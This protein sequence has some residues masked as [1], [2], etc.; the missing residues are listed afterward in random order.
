MAYANWG[1]FTNEQ[2]VQF[3]GRGNEQNM[4]SQPSLSL[5]IPGIR[6]FPDFNPASVLQGAPIGEKKTASKPGQIGIIIFPYR[7]FFSPQFFFPALNCTLA[8][9]HQQVRAASPPPTAP[10]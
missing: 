10:Q 7:I 9:I 4:R 6:P 3:N 1:E 2:G 5:E 8:R